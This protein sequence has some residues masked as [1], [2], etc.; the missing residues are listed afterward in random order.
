[1]STTED[2]VARSVQEIFE[3]GA[4]QPPQFSVADIRR[5]RSRRWPQRAAVVAVA[6]AIVVVFFVP[7]PRLSLFNRLSH[8]GTPT[9]PST[10]LPQTGLPSVDQ[11][12][13]PP[14]WVPVAYKDAQISIPASWFVLYRTAPCLV[15]KPSGQAPSGEA[16]VNPLRGIYFCT[17]A[18]LPQTVVWLKAIPTNARGGAPKVING[19]TVYPYPAGQMGSYLVP[20]LGVEITATGRLARR[21]LRTLTVSP[22]SVV[23][24]QGHAPAIPPHWQ[25]LSF[26][27]LA[28]AAPAEW[29]VA[30]AP[31]Y[32]WFLSQGMCP[33]MV[34]KH[35]TPLVI[36]STD[37]SF[38]TCFLTG[39]SPS[40]PQDGLEIASKPR[41]PTVKALTP[42]F[43]TRC[44]ALNDL[45]VCPAT[46]PAYSILVLKV[47]VPGR[48]KPAIVSIGL[49]GNGMVARTI[50]YS[51]TAIGDTSDESPEPV[52]QSDRGSERNGDGP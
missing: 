43:S 19:I 37:K 48:S 27:G 15:D 51:L 35:V 5:R 41:K 46:S 44:F 40:I 1:M 9:T 4:A 24:A 2:R 33:G 17:H 29:P 30:H 18:V 25:K 34:S 42:V 52:C 14:G 31:Y 47:T 36:L 12:A 6:A 23:L 13:T 7:L 21:V 16:F 22:R 39:S 28:F 11:S 45:R 10:F 26:Q 38:A 3:F 20:S 50:L 49:A 8:T 32:L